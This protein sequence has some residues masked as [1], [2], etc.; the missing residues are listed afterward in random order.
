M[1]LGRYAHSS[2][3]ATTDDIKHFKQQK[4][5]WINEVNGS[6]NEHMAYLIP[7]HKLFTQNQNIKWISSNKYDDTFQIF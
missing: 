4:T 3:L 6:D 7:A 5:N 1:S 2:D